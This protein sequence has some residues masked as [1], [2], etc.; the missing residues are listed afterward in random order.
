[1]SSQKACNACTDVAASDP[2]L[3]GIAKTQTFRLLKS[4]PACIYTAYTML[5]LLMKIVPTFESA[6]IK[7]LGD[8]AR[9]Q[10]TVEEA[11]FCGWEF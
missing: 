7:C 2:L 9:Y 11:D 8:L 5:I 10:M 3:S 4:H 6:W 1:M